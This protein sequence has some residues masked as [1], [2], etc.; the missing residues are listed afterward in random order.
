[1]NDYIT[2]IRTKTGDKQIDY[3]ALGNLPDSLPASDVSDWAKQPVKPSYTAEEIGADN[4][5]SAASAETNA[6]KYTDD[7][8]RQL[9][10]TSPENMDTI[11]ELGSAVT[12]NK[13]AIDI[14]EAAITNKV[15]KVTGKGLSST[16]VTS[17]MVETWNAKSD[18]SGSYNDLT[19]V[20]LSLPA[21]DVPDW[22]KA[23]TKPVY[24]AEEVHALPDTTDIPVVSNDL[25][26]ELK[27]IYD[28]AVQKSHSHG[29]KSI[30]DGIT[31]E[32]ISEWDNK[33]DFNGDYN[34]LE[35]KPVIPEVDATLSIENNAADSK[36]TGEKFQALDDTKVDKSVLLSILNNKPTVETL[37]E[38][39][40]L[41][42]TDKVYQVK[43]PKFAS[44]PTSTCEKLGANEGLVFEPSTDTVEGQDDYADKIEFMWWHNNYVRNDEGYAIITALETDTQYAETGSV[45]V[46]SCGM[47]FYYKW[48]DSN[49]DY[50]ILSWSPSPHSE[51]GLVPFS[52][53][54]PGHSYWCLS[55]YPSIVASDGLLRSQPYGKIARNQ[56]HNNMITNYQKKGTGYWGAGSERNTFQIIFNAIMGATKSSQT[57]YAG[58]TNWNIQYDAAIERDTEDTYF[59]VTAAQA[60]NLEVGCYVSVGYGANN[61]GTLNKDRGVSTMHSY[62]DN[63]KILR[64]EDM[65]DGNKAV[66]LDID[67]G[68]STTSVTLTDELFSPIIM[69]SMHMWTGETNKV[70]GKHN[71]SAISNSS[72][73]HS[74]R[75]QGVEYAL[76]AYIVASDTIMDFQTDYSKNVYIAPKGT[77]HSSSEATIK[78][79]YT[80]L[81]NIPASADGNGSDY[82]IG[83]IDIDTGTGCWYPISEGASSAQGMGD[84]IYAGGT[85]TS[86]IRE[87]LQGGHLW[88]GSVAGASFL[89]CRLGLGDGWWYFA[90]AD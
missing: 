86:G 60:A 54:V 17:D 84:R 47:S 68:F 24:T 25:T 42:R 77:P 20:P 14:I 80:L 71:G 85:A 50:I 12:E 59:P 32:K 69:S 40:E 7:V 88:S 8:V 19:D 62:A 5:G 26:D 57:L 36:I 38:F 18:F 49:D 72:G 76:G 30:L 44:N 31:D 15:D 82:W 11:E 27:N 41:Q 34:S 89:H 46:G 37:D 67:T 16:D 79:T 65:D 48:D 9:I 55:A 4:R 74:Y 70:I 2:K 33:S 66:Y 78:S 81:G 21:S 63:V 3:N 23:K 22:A 39:L 53:N 58:V 13:D 75:V 45:D 1:M 10:G 51:L 61:N 90:A 35:N 29:N 52:A 56:S 87:Y 64:I 6:K 28:D 73:R 83:D 43:I